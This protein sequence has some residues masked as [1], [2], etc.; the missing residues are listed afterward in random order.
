MPDY[1]RQHNN[2][3][4][5]VA[6]VSLL[7]M[8]PWTSAIVTPLAGL[9]AHTFMHRLL[10]WAVCYKVYVLALHTYSPHDTV[11][12]PD[13][14]YSKPDWG[15]KP[16]FSLQFLPAGWAKKRNTS[17]ESPLAAGVAP[18]VFLDGDWSTCSPQQS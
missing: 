7:R 1:D 15:G 16:S 10:D 4:M 14:T 17:V 6:F 5:I 12:S 11:F 8:N 9:D 2:R 3:V 18:W 13:R